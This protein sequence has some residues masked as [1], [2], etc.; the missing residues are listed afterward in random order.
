MAK[1]IPIS[2]T[3]RQLAIEG[4]ARG[5]KPSQIAA[6][7]GLSV[8]RIRNLQK[9]QEIADAVDR[10]RLTDLIPG[11]LSALHDTMLAVLSWLKTT[12]SRLSA[13]EEEIRKVRIGNHR[14]QVENKNL[15][16]TRRDDRKQLREAKA[17]LWRARG[18]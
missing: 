9:K 14:L 15:R 11:Q 13:V 3:Q 12:D 8:Y 7:T 5:D 4:F 6:S 18:Y 17:A 1:Q 2:D 16:E 10:M